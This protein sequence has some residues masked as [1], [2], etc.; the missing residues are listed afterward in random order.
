[1][2]N[3]TRAIAVALAF[4]A[5]AMP[6]QAEAQ[7]AVIIG[8]V[9]SE[10]G[11]PIEGAN[12]FITEMA[13]SVGTNSEGNYTITIP[14]ARADGR[15]VNLRVRAFGYQ[16]QVRPL[17]VTAGSQTFDFA[18]RQDVNRLA[19]VVVT[20]VTAGTE[21][22][23]LPFTVA[24]VD[25]SQMPVPGSNPLTQLQ[26]KVA[27]VSIMS[28]SGRPGAT[29]SVLL[30]G[31]QSINASGRSQGPLYIIDGVVVDGGLPDLNP[32]DIESVEVV[33][34]AAASSLYG[35][36]AGSGVIQITTK[37]GQNA[38]AGIKFNARTEYGQ[39]DIEKEYE[40]ARGHFLMMDETRTLFCVAGTNCTR[41]VDFD[42]EA[43]RVNDGGGDFA[44]D[45]TT[46]ERDHG[47]GP[48]PSRARLHGLFQAERWSRT[49]NPIA[50][51]VT[52]G[53]NWSNAI[54]AQGRVG[55]TR[56][57]TS[58]SNFR[59]DGAFKYVPGYQRNSLRLN[60]DQDVGNDWTF[61]LRSFYSTSYSNGTVHEDGGTAFFRLTRVPGGV[62]LTRRDSKGRLFIRSNPLNQGGQNANALYLFESQISNRDRERFLSNFSTRYTPLSW[63]E[64]QADAA[65][66][67]TTD[68]LWRQNPKG[69]RTTSQATTTNGGFLQRA[70]GVNSNYN[71]SVDVRARH[72]FTSDLVTRATLR[73]LYE[74]Q[75]DENIDAQGSV[76]VAGGL[77]DL[78]AVTDRASFDI[79]SGLQSIRSIGMM[80][81][82]DAEYKE[83]YIV[84]LLA[85][86]D[87]SSLFG[88]NNRW[89]N[90]GRASVAWRAA[91]EPWWFAPQVNELKL[92]AS[93]GTAGGRPR[94]DAQYETFT[95]GDNGAL[96]KNTLGNRNLRP[97]TVTETE[98]G[99][100]AE[101]LNRFGV[102][103]NYA[104][105]ISE[106]QLLPVPPSLSSGFVNQWKNAGT[107]ENTTWEASI[108]VPI[109]QQR[110]L[111]WSVRANWD[112][113]R[114]FI[115]KLD[116]PEFFGGPNQQGAGS[117]FKFAEGERYGTF[118]GRAFVT[119]CAELEEP[120][121]S[122][123]GGPG[124]QFQRNDQGFI[125][126]TG[127]RG[128]DEGITGNY[129]MSE[130]PGCVNSA[131]VAQA[132]VGV[133]N[134]QAAGHNVNAPSGVIVNW[135]IPIL[136][137]DQ[138]GGA[139]QVRLGN[140]LPDYR[141]GISQTL[142][143]K[144][145]FVYALFDGVMGRD[146]FNEGRHWSLGDFM[147][148]ETD[149]LGKS[150]A[151]AKPLGYYFRSADD[152]RGLG[153]LY[154]ALGP[155]N[156]T[157]EDASYVKLRELNLSYQIGQVRGYGDWTV[158][159]IGRNLM[160]FSKYHG[161]DPEVGFSSNNINDAANSS[162]INALDAYT[163]PNLRTF[164]FAIQTRF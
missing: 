10:F 9:T 29:Q 122:Q 83:R 50:S 42:A 112:R 79:S 13:I 78:D 146:V 15:Q 58:M 130:L 32:M 56:F 93:V 116:V 36:R 120:F 162:Q 107:M 80:T 123:C 67:R 106:D 128:L 74:Q 12:V 61:G 60:L 3:I 126:W 39:G 59:Q 65:F 35:S 26:G 81:G 4:L 132:I 45:P 52:P 144:K 1:M 2:R 37:S 6:G 160:T 145:F 21:Q 54:D 121:R 138:N 30:R 17:R 108:N 158:T 57:F 153:G 104:K 136:L 23:K 99:V 68:R 91:A 157:T 135:G 163:F 90:Y 71:G 89:A 22:K 16:P 98:I 85:R 77:S 70:S 31:P 43:F 94:F 33:K 53:A 38:S 96:S 72:D 20:G 25:E 82:V 69:F 131:G 41:T 129:W 101:V 46:F 149:Q 34:G 118:Y 152:A 47:I 66:D 161:F 134:C 154:D 49:Y 143:Y 156:F 88:A 148:K 63:L 86:R 62:D 159:L 110:N 14:A 105:A 127:G 115:T 64:V 141:L 28:T 73:Y 18:M 75:D 48:G 133:V 124:A 24:R 164:T 7:N 87:G 44:L 55:G 114:A 40:W 103:L 142:N 92:R 102:T 8:R 11:Q 147:T 151:T 137:R 125:V 51:V 139:R 155:N 84:G 113:N 109:I 150:V 100:D 76:L 27:G 140:A 119:S 19:E 5:I 111:N 117:M 97:E 95:I